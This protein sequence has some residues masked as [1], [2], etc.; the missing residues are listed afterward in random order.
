M[1]KHVGNLDFPSRGRKSCHKIV[2]NVDYEI[3]FDGFF[4]AI[5]PV[6]HDLLVIFVKFFSVFTHEEACDVVVIFWTVEAFKVHKIL[7][8]QSDFIFV[9]FYLQFVLLL[10]RLWFLLLLAIGFRS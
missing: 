5:I 7:L 8:D 9:W 3:D 2:W 1:R 10:L 6:I 4:D